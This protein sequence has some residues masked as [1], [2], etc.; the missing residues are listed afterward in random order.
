MKNKYKSQAV[1]QI[2]LEQKNRTPKSEEK[3]RCPSVLHIGHC[4]NPTKFN[5]EKRRETNVLF[6]FH[7][8]VEPNIFVGAWYF[9]AWRLMMSKYGNVGNRKISQRC[10]TI[11]QSLKKS[12]KNSN[13]KNKQNKQTNKLPFSL[14]MFYPLFPIALHVKDPNG[15]NGWQ[16]AKMKKSIP[17]MSLPWNLKGWSSWSKKLQKYLKKL[18]YLWRCEIWGNIVIIWYFVNNCLIK[19][20]I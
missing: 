15:V 1:C 18:R 9:E 3:I 20:W 7:S 17:D 5:C 14:V 13:V 10:L 16:L 6:V 4:K 12:Q 11:K 8:V 19:A 2:E